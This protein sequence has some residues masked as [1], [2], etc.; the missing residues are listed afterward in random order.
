MELGESSVIKGSDSEPIAVFGARLND[1]IS[2]NW[3]MSNGIIRWKKP[4]LLS[5]WA[6]NKPATSIKPVIRFISCPL[7]MSV[8]K[9]I[10]NPLFNTVNIFSKDEMKPR[11]QKRIMPVIGGQA[12]PVCF[13]LKVS[14]PRVR[15]KLFLKTKYPTQHSVD[16]VPLVP[17]SVCQMTSTRA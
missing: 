10:L 7:L 17:I 4:H 9:S 16:Y 1:L 11:L 5:H 12:L 3:S 15:L 13:N 8:L 14:S 2:N 6:D